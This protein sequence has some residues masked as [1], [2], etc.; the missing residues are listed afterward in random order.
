MPGPILAVIL[1]HRVAAK[2]DPELLAE[3]K[4]SIGVRLDMLSLMEKHK[5]QD[6]PEVLQV[7]VCNQ[8]GCDI[9]HAPIGDGD[10]PPWGD[11]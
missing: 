10:D 1:D 9:G 2:V 5:D 7:C 4:E 11:D 6:F 3:I 8:E